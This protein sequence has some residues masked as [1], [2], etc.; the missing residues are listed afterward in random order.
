MVIRMVLDWFSFDSNNNPKIASVGTF[1]S[2]NY[3]M[4]NGSVI[5]NNGQ[6]QVVVNPYSISKTLPVYFVDNN[7]VSH[8]QGSIVIDANNNPRLVNNGTFDSNNYYMTTGKII[9]NNGQYQINVTP[10]VNV[11]YYPIQFLDSISG[12]NVNGQGQVGVFNGDTNNPK[13]TSISSLDS[14]YYLNNQ[15][16]TGHVLPLIFNGVAYVYVFAKPEFADSLASQSSASA[17]AYIANSKASLAQS[18]A[19]AISSASSQLTQLP[20]VLQLQIQQL[21]VQTIKI[22]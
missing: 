4:A 21:L 5:N 9:N 14:N 19:N 12:K 2:N 16:S 11:V 15:N 13:V 8:G 18:I 1:D 10:T 17:A 20:I 3:Y 22:H 7:N 6:Y